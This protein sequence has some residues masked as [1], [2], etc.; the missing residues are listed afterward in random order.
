MFFLEFR[1]LPNFAAKIKK[2]SQN[3]KQ[4]YNLK[5]A[6]KLSRLYILKIIFLIYFEGVKNHSHRPYE[7][8]LGDPARVLLDTRAERSAK[9]RWCQ[10]QASW[11]EAEEGE[12]QEASSLSRKL[13]VSAR[14][15]NGQL[16]P[17]VTRSAT[18]DSLT[19]QSHCSLLAC[20]ASLGTE[21][22]WPYYNFSSSN[23]GQTGFCCRHSFSLS[24]SSSVLSSPSYPEEQKEKGGWGSPVT[25]TK[26][27][28]QTGKNS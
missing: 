16:S 23:I 18:P 6:E 17:A 20:P 15:S 8:T 4:K 24:S 10:I 19:T 3:L 13:S 1:E 27:G 5:I 11:S 25:P 22:T 26:K 28:P 2:Y 9:N 12:T 14:H 21:K 7:N